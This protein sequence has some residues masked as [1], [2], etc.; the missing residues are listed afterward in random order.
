MKDTFS[1]SRPIAVSADGAELMIG[2]L[3]AHVEPGRMGSMTLEIFDEQALSA[4]AVAVGD[5]IAAFR[6]VATAFAQDHG[7]MLL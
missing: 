6:E 4:N 7:G 2:M 3:H 5:Q 1:F